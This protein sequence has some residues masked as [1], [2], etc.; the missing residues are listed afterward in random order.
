[1]SND[2]AVRG[3]YPGYRARKIAKIGLV[4]SLIF[5]AVLA[6]VGTWLPG[7]VSFFGSMLPPSTSQTLGAC[8]GTS[9]N[10]T[11][12]TNTCPSPISG[13]RSITPNSVGADPLSKIALPKTVVSSVDKS[14]LAGGVIQAS[15][16]N[17]TLYNSAITLRLLGGPTPHDE[18]LSRSYNILSSYL[19]WNVQANISGIWTPLSPVSNNFTIIGTNS[20]GTFLVRAMK[21]SLGSYAGVLDIV[22]K[23]TSGGPLKWDLEF[24]PVTSGNYRIGLTWLNVTS[25]NWLLPVSKQFTVRYGAVNYTLGWSDISTFSTTQSVTP[26]QFVLSIDLGWANAGSLVW[27]DPSIITS[28]VGFS[29]DTFQRRVFFEPNGGYYWVFYYDGTNNVYR[30]SANGIQWSAS[31]AVPSGVNGLPWKDPPYNPDVFDFGQTVVLVGASDASGSCQSPCSGSDSLPYVIGTISGSSISWGPVQTEDTVTRG[32]CPGA[33][34]GTY[35]AWEIAMSYVDV[36]RSSSGQLAFSYLLTVSDAGPNECSGNSSVSALILDYNGGRL[37]ASCTGGS[38]AILLPSNSQGQVRVV[39]PVPVGGSSNQ[40]LQSRWFDGVNAGSVDSLG[41]MHGAVGGAN[42]I[43]AVSDANYGI[44]VLFRGANNNASYAYLPSSPGS[45]W[46]FSKDIFSVMV[47][48]ATI[49]ADY[50]TNEVYAF[51][52]NGSSIVMKNKPFGE[53]WSDSSTVYV[54]TGRVSPSAIGSNFASASATANNQTLLVWTETTNLMFASIP[55]QTVWSPYSAPPD[56]WNGNGLAPYGQY[57]ANLGEYVSP[58]TGIFTIKQTDLTLA[59]RGLSL[60]ITRV[61]TEPYSFLNSQP[62]NYEAY[63][64]APMGDGWQLNFPW[65]SGMTYPLYVHLWD[66][67]G[68][69]IPLSFWSGSTATLENH[70]G[71]NFRLVRYVNGTIVLFDKSGTSY[72]FGIPPNYPNHALTSITDSTGNSTITLNY[73]SNVI[74]CISDTV[75]RAFSFSY[76]GGLL[77]KIS[78]INGSCASPGSSIRTVTYGNNG[79]SLMSVTDPANRVT[80]YLPG[81]NPWLISRITYP[82]GWYDS[83]SYYPPY[84]LGTQATTYRVSLQQVMA[85]SSSTVR[86]FAYSYAQGAGDQITGSTV[87][88]YN[89]TQIASYTKYAFSFLMDVKN[90]TD[91]SGNLLSGDEQVFGVTGQIPKEIVFVTDGQGHIGSYTN[92]YSYDL[93]GDQIYSRQVINPSS[94]SYH[95]SFNSYYN[96]AEPPGFYAFEDSFSRNQGTASDNSWNVTNGYWMVNNGVYNGTETSGAQESMFASSSVGKT[97]IS[98]QAR[99]YITRQVNT[100][101]YAYGQRVG[102][103]VHSTGS[104]TNKWALVLQQYPNGSKYLQMFDEWNSENVAVPFQWATGVWYTFNMTVHGLQSTGWVAGPGQNPISISLT[105]LPSGPAVSGTGFGPYAGGYSAL[106]D[107]VQVAAVSPYITGSGFSNSF[108]QNG[109]PGQVGVNTWLTTTKPPGTGWNRVVNW[110]P[111]SGWSQGYVSQNYGATPWGTITGWPDTSAQWIWWDTNANVSA[112]S[113]NV[114]F[115]RVFSVPTTTSLSVTITSDNTYTLY[116]DGN[117]LGTGSN[118]QQPGSYAASVSPGYHVLAIYATNPDGP[119]AAGLLV[120]VKNTATSQVIFRSD[121]TA[122][123]IAGAIAGAIAGTAQLQNGPGSLPE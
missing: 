84:T 13:P 43:S 9:A 28:T 25:A 85:G 113:D 99:V 23:A 30:N 17:L 8:P 95:E 100:T 120:S 47:N 22:Y 94:N 104:G 38:Q 29:Y 102:I 36:V 82:T 40:T 4:S 68:Y 116:L 107:D 78:Q 109:A 51:G 77:T 110:L 42:A 119:D 112:S 62:L 41:G 87:T 117:Q 92:Y 45:S 70:Q 21:V 57:F 88:S 27:I 71:E 118:W 50:S 76:S 96:N 65:L 33:A 20:S 26:E 14:L 108:I 48:S 66:G 86:Q 54:I 18:I 91:A 105:F 15:T 5:L 106:F 7:L 63:P 93:W 19:F 53:T 80:T 24:I 34:P 37:V 98:L 69:R 90:T 72:R 55:L 35:C 49:T 121:A 6:S 103:F 58:S 74:S 3:F 11:S 44:H 67:E 16:T 73:L 101:A 115:R 1:M 12:I 52:I 122:G 79:A 64:W 75:Q 56:P 32:A 2:Q 60:D 81:S 61:Y 10:S 97:D 31:T 111:A 39:Y 114:Y 83:Y 89:G 59:G 46:S 123:P